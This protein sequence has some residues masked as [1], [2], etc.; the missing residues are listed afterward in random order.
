MTKTIGT[1]TLPAMDPSSMPGMTAREMMVRNLITL[2][3]NM[4]ALEALDILLSN[5]ISGAP[6]VDQD[7]MFLGV[8]SEK[9]CMQFVVSLA[10]DGMPSTDVQSLI[11][12][13]PPT[14][15]EETDLLT[16]AQAFLTQSCRRLPVLDQ[17]GKLRGQVSRRDVM[18]AVR[19]H[20]KAPRK[21]AA[22][23]GLFFSAILSSSERR[24]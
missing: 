22:A 21:S 11:D 23:S 16:I 4:D 18:R 15:G 12:A 8:F 2:D 1:G 17:A 14:I 6:V 20:L 24:F 3:P 13:D 7:G 10:Y 19:S 9:S 5:R